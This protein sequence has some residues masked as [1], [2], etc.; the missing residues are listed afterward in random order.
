MAA[1]AHPPIASVPRRC[2]GCTSTGAGCR[3]GTVVAGCGGR[4]CCAVVVVVAAAVVVRLGPSGNACQSGLG[5]DPGRA[6]AIR[7]PEP[8][9]AV[10]PR[11]TIAARARLDRA[12]RIAVS[13]SQMPQTQTN[14]QR[15]RSTEGPVEADKRRLW[16][17]RDPVSGQIEGGEHMPA[18]YDQVG[19][20]V[21]L[22]L[23][24]AEQSA[25][26][27]REEA[28]KE[29]DDLRTR[30]Q[31]DAA[32]LE[33]AATNLQRE[34]ERTAAELREAA[35]HD[36][37]EA[38][39]RAEEEARRIIA[40]A[41]R[42]AAGITRAAERQQRDLETAIVGGEDRLR[43]LAAT[44]HEVARRLEQVIRPADASAGGAAQRQPKD[45][46]L[47]ALQPPSQST[48]TDDKTI[49]VAHAER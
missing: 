43:Q 20:R 3:A 45:D 21:A 38:R 17:R 30:A 28:A 10:H 29:A 24:A 15:R 42:K 46:V 47:E 32:K 12:A 37:S 14:G 27:M 35:S 4:G 48:R 23:A 19:K 18:D 22:V 49:E 34:A 44:L 36:A 41:E 33:L 1:I 16:R 7:A 25:T 9:R 26:E 39:E 8:K 40:S 31:A 5:F 6:D 11:T 2:G 13:V